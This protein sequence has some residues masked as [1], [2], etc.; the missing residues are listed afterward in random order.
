MLEQTDILK[1]TRACI[2]F[3]LDIIKRNGYLNLGKEPVKSLIV[4]KKTCN[5]PC[6]FITQY[7]C[8]IIFFEKY[9][10]NF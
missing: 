5:N 3:N 1:I 2:I 10:F 6:I 7:S 9:I 8:K 4:R